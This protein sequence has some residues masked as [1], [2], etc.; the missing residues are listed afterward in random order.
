MSIDQAR[1][2]LQRQVTSARYKRVVI[3][4]AVSLSPVL[5]LL[6]KFIE[7]LRALNTLLKEMSFNILRSLKFA[8]EE[9]VATV[10]K[11]QLEVGLTKVDDKQNL[12]QINVPI[13]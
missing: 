12:K 11:I 7:L 6:L 2:H 13:A 1:P 9:Y 5:L 8:L 4:S 10:E 3:D